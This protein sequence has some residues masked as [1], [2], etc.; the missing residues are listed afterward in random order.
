MRTLGC[1]AVAILIVSCGDAR[2]GHDSPLRCVFGIC[3]MCDDWTISCLAEKCTT[4]WDA[5][6]LRPGEPGDI[7]SWYDESYCS[8]GYSCVAGCC[9]ADGQ[10]VDGS[11]R[12]SPPT[13]VYLHGMPCE[14]D[15]DCEVD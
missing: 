8:D 15:A 7:D 2:T 1:V 10:S 3:S 14:V 5:C 11:D 9:Q 12:P 4:S 6:M 13:I